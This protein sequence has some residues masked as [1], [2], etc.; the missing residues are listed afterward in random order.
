MAFENT[1]EHGSVVA[2]HFRPCD[3]A[4]GRVYLPP[5]ESY[6]VIHVEDPHI[7]PLVPPWQFQV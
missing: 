3:L 7:S 2:R 1:V 6:D 5:Q 4:A